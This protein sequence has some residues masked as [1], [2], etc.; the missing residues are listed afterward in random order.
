MVS[1]APVSG[2][3]FRL[4]QDQCVGCAIC[5]DVCPTDA[6]HMGYND[7]LPTCIVRLC[8]ACRACEIE[9][10]T[11]AIRIEKRRA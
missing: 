10:P 9:C 6:I 5:A 3:E 2:I 11:A 8:T 4:E 7:I 1:D